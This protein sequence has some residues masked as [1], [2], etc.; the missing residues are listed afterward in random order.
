M[1]LALSFV[2]KSLAF[3][4]LLHLR[5]VLIKSV[6]YIKVTV[7]LFDLLT[8]GST[9]RRLEMHL[10]ALTRF[11]VTVGVPYSPSYCSQV[12]AALCF[13]PRLRRFS[14]FMG[15]VN[16]NDLSAEGWVQVGGC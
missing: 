2:S 13:A 14:E 12:L 6:K 11:E 4:E 9:T 15:A 7:D 5:E 1:S 16:F 10:L 3:V 8:R